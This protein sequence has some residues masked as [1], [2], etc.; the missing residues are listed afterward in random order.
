MSWERD[1]DRRLKGL[2]ARRAP[3]SLSTRI[4]VAA[5]LQARPWHARP[6][7]T[8]SPAGQAA[9]LGALA[10][11]AAALAGTVNEPLAG[12]VSLAQERLGWLQVLTGALGRA[13]FTAR[14][15]LGAAVALCLTIC[16]LPTAALLALPR[17]RSTEKP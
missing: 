11:A 4:L 3:L 13:A 10:L 1:L 7:W 6:Y 15:P 12:A 9:F 16:V 8:W 5:Q 14:A 2:P 17:A